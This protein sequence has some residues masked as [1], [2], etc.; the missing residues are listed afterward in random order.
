MTDEAQFSI[1][2]VLTSPSVDDVKSGRP[3]SSGSVRLSTADGVEEYSL[4]LFTSSVRKAL[5][6]V[7]KLLRGDRGGVPTHDEAYLVFELED[8]QHGHVT[9]CYSRDA[10]DDPKR[11]V[12]SRDQRSLDAILPLPVLVDEAVTAVADLLDR[13]AQLNESVDE[14]GWFQNLNGELRSV[15]DVADGHLQ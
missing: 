14:Y 15:R 12:V 5:D 13:I 7:K 1:G 6:A 9:L 11:R 10:I 8:E 3:P 4:T 2:F